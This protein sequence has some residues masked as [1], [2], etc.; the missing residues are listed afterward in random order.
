[1]LTLALEPVDRC[2]QG[3]TEENTLE[4]KLES[5]VHDTGLNTDSE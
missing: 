1:M 3:S 4:K 5:I 2:S